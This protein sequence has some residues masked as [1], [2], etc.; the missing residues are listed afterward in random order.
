ME[1]PPIELDLRLKRDATG[2]VGSTPWQKILA[3]LRRLDDGSSYQTLDDQARVS[4]E[5]IR[6]AFKTFCTALRNEYGSEFLNR[7][8]TVAEMES[9]ERSFASK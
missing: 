1:L 8:P 2:R 4:A 3:A 6:R 5:S 9:T 7:P